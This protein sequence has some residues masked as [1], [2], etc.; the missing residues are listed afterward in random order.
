MAGRSNVGKSSL[1]NLVCGQKNLARV[2]QQ[3]GKTDALI[4]YEVDGKLWLI[5]LPGFGFAKG[6][7]KKTSAF[8]QLVDDFLQVYEG[9]HLILLVIDSRRG[10]QEG[11]GALM[12]F[13]NAHNIPLKIVCNKIDQLKQSELMKLKREFGDR[14]IFTSVPKRRGID[15]LRAVMAESADL[16]AM[17]LD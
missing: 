9:L 7:K 12:A 8:M 3:P 17:D 2:S 14:A 5:D 1:I 6:A 15:E 13:A 4:F 16:E 11:E 10:L